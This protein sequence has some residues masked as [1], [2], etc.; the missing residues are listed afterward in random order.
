V[1]DDLLQ[2]YENELRFLRGMGA[3]F[4]EKYPKIA[5]RL[6]L[7]A[8]KCED[9]HVERLLEGVALLAARVHL[10]IDDEF[11]EIVEAL[12]NILYP[13]YLRPI[14]S[15]SIAEFQVDS[16]QVEPE[17]GL[18]V[19]RGAT[20][21]SRQ[22][23]GAP[24]RF[25]T[26]YDV[27]FWPLE[28]AAAEWKP[29]DRL[30]LAGRIG[31]ATGAVR[32]ELRCQGDLT[33][34]KIALDSLRFYLHG[35]SAFV[36]TLYEILDNNC[37][38]ILVRD[39]TPKSKREPV[40]LPADCLKPAGFEERDGMLPYPGRSFAGYQL[41]QEYFSFPQKFFF[42]D[43]AGFD[44]IRAAGF[45]SAIELIFLVSPFEIA[46]R[47]Q[48]L[49]TQVTAGTFRLN[50]APIVNLFPLVAEPIL[51]D[52]TR[53]DY[54]VIPD[55][56]RRAALEIFSVEGVSGARTGSERGFPIEPL[57]SF[58]HSAVK[59]TGEVFWYASRIA[60]PMRNDA[61]TE[62]KLAIANA[63]GSPVVPDADTLTVHTLCTNRDLPGRLPFGNE[64][65]D[66]TLESAAPVKRIV[67]LV[68]PTPTVRPPVGR[69]LAWRLLSQLS[70]NYLSLVEDGLESFQEILRLYNF[71]DTAH[72]DK[73]V[74]GLVELSNRP[75]FAPVANDMAVFF[76][77]GTRIEMLFDEEQYVGG[78][79][80]L[81]SAV[82]ERFLGMYVS[83]NSFVQLLVKTRQRR[84]ALKLWPPRAG[85]RILI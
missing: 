27:T 47:R 41:L 67:A 34:S 13:H 49:E 10:K 25:R 79:V 61:G 32:V 46:D 26:A 22:V 63:A 39:L 12:L 6:V 81:F 33:F 23:G 83:L 42:F 5:S 48:V 1:R 73:Q 7:E 15:M 75:H 30:N 69:S 85:R 71:A 66:F 36:H 21:A 74:D 28:V 55:V 80:Y 50:C 9:P 31:D 60:S 38:E 45:G 70:L 20:L 54:Q 78:G 84:E 77:R 58:R 11:P 19:A 52:H 4:A 40:T 24:C 18:K 64:A 62:I 8:N 2:Y 16:A 3:E 57:Y 56:T 17:S 35:E 43:L 76:A 44:R 59:R 82:L 72:G 14:P 37:V 65:G 29:A 68:K 51:L 53:Y